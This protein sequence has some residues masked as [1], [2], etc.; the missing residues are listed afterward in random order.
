MMAHPKGVKKS[1][2]KF[3]YIILKAPSKLKVY[4]NTFGWRS[5]VRDLYRPVLFINNTL[6]FVPKK[7]NNTFGWITF[8]RT[9]VLQLNYENIV[10][11]AQLGSTKFP[12]RSQEHN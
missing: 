6:F 2:L 12:L 3:E 5:Q 8:I 4:F 11:Q 7:K 9:F 1:L 10:Q